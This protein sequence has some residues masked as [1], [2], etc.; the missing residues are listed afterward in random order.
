MDQERRV[1]LAHGGGGHLSRELIE[2]EILP[3]FSN[4]I[5]N[6]LPDTAALTV[7]GTHILFTTDSFVVQPLFFPG[8]CI[9]DLAV[10]GTVNDLAVSGGRPLFLTLALILEE[11]LPW[12]TLRQVLEA[13]RRA[14]TACGVSVV[15]GDTK[16]VRRGQCDG[17]YLNVSGLGMAWPGFQLS[18]RSIRPGDAVLVSGTL[19]NHGMAVLVA[20]E[21]LFLETALVSDSAPV[22]RLVEAM[23]PWT[24]EVRFMRDPTRGGASPPCCTRPP[25]A[26]VLPL[27]SRPCPWTPA[28]AAVAEMLGISLLHSPCEGRIMAVVAPEV[29][30]AV[31]AAWRALP[32]GQ[33]ACR[34][35]QAI[36]PV[37]RVSLHTT[38]GGHTLIDRP[39]GEM[40]PRIC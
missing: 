30:Q 4:E 37:G 11:G 20:R 15:T 27:R 5:L 13:V 39:Q 19:G 40:L 22:H 2:R 29:T 26:A 23:L 6:A 21:K 24:A 32:E 8:G 25:W 18:A 1:L 9:G 12:S 3:R 31:L 34:I 28:A 17:L 10:H 14:T 35:G 38:L 33:G 36:A 7:P 16:V